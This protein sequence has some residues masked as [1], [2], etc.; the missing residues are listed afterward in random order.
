MV[1]TGC[2][3]QVTEN[4]CKLEIYDSV[5][6]LTSG[7]FQISGDFYVFPGLENLLYGAAEERIQLH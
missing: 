5:I 4:A 7:M 3:F 2:Q 1:Q 6:A